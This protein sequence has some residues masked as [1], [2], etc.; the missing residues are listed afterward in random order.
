V[1]VKARVGKRKGR[2]A[3][4]FALCGPEAL[5]SEASSEFFCGSLS[6]F[7]PENTGIMSSMIIRMAMRAIIR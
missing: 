3:G 2:L 5:G 4:G 6:G 1:N 7:L